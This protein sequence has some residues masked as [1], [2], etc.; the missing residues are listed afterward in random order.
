MN[1]NINKNAWEQEHVSAWIE[2]FGPPETYA[3]KLKANPHGPIINLESQFGSI[4]GKNILNVMGSN[5]N[6]AVALALL[7]AQVTV[8]DFSESNKQ[9]A[10]E[11]AKEA[12]VNI[13]YILCDILKL[14][15]DDQYDLAFAEMG[16]LHYFLDLEVFYN[17]LYKV[18]KSGGELIIRD[19]HPVSTKLI[20]SRGSTAK[21]RK[22]KVEGDYFDS[23]LVE[24]TVSY[25]KYIAG[26]KSEKA[27]K[28]FLRNWTLGEIVTSAANVGFKVVSLTEEP[29][30]SSDVYD[31]GIP[32][33]FIIKLRK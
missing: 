5:G 1:E 12:G 9:Y 33:T 32:K 15:V 17:V 4:V 27:E 23:N 11:L 14:E 26:E 8:V 18:L 10:L 24:K 22:H 31:K 6:K 29:N 30:K 16:I 3:L 28:V 25:G 19:F 20:S 2:R 21:V 7:G 13:N